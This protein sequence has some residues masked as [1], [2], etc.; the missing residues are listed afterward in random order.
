MCRRKIGSMRQWEWLKRDQHI[1]GNY[2]SERARPVKHVG[3]IMTSHNDSVIILFLAQALP[4]FSYSWRRQRRRW[5]WWS[6]F[7]IS[8]YAHANSTVMTAWLNVNPFSFGWMMI[9]L[10][11]MQLERFVFSSS[12]DSAW[13]AEPTSSR[14]RC[15]RRCWWCWWWFDAH[16]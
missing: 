2:G 8:S 16:Q 12:S 1:F 6:I 9:N 15:L 7:S 5:W 10:H 13:L 11:L 14:E 4:L 3:K